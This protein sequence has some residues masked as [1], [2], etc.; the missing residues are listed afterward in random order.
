MGQKGA[1]GCFTVVFGMIF[2]VAALAI[3]AIEVGKYRDASELH[4]EMDLAHKDGI[5]TSW[6]EYAASIPTSAPEDNAAEFYRQFLKNK[7]KWPDEHLDAVISL[8]PTPTAIAE[9]EKYVADKRED[10]DLLEQATRRK[11]CWYK[12]NWQ[13]G[14]AVLMPELATMKAGVRLLTYRASLHAAQG[15]H[16]LAVEDLQRAA[17]I[18]GH[19]GQETTSISF[20]VSESCMD[21]CL[22]RLSLLMQRY[23][24][25]PEYS[26]LMERLL[27]SY[28]IPNMRQIH[29][30]DLLE[31]QSVVELCKT[32]KGRAE[33]GLKEDDRSNLESIVPIFVSRSRA[34]VGMVKAGRELYRAYGLPAHERLNPYEDAKHK[35]SKSMFAYQTAYDIYSKLSYGSDEEEA[36][37]DLYSLSRKVK[38]ASMLK[39]LQSKRSLGQKPMTEFKS[40]FDNTPVTCSFDGKQVSINVSGVTKA[41]QIEPLKIP[42]DRMLKALTAKPKKP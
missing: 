25:L 24:T 17:I 30:S 21:L 26:L 6:A 40:P 12:R 13:L 29:R 34:D 3:I 18:A 10:F 38:Y 2:G 11:N 23:G 20:M 36:L 28:P 9:A 7:R 39:F 15:K 27:R 16:K 32:A 19:A 1:R 42:S 41:S 8:K 14:L 5:A 37:L 35:L 31:V 22:S 4:H 33:L